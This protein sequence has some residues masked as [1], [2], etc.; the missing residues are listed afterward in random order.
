MRT[1]T[2]V[3]AFLNAASANPLPKEEVIARLGEALRRN[4]SYWTYRQRRGV[5]T[6]YLDALESE[7]EAIASA[8]YDL[9][10]EA[11]E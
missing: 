6:P 11:A 1:T 3:V 2:D 7:M 9:Q 4:L 8:I 5:H 10:K